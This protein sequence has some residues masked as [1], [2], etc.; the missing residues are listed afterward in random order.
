MSGAVALPGLAGDL[1]S[2]VHRLAPRTKV[3]GLTAVTLVAVSAGPSRWPV[4]VA[5]LIAL[6]GVAATA[7]VPVAVAARR[8]RVVLPL[9]VLAAGA[10]PLVRAGGARIELGPVVLWEEGLLALSAV[11]SKA[12]IGTLSAVL[13]GATTSFPQILRALQEL[14]VPRLFVVIAQTTHR[15]LPVVIGE[16]RR[17]HTALLARGWRPRN[18]LRAAPVGRVAGT[19]FL[20]AHARGERV[21]RAMLART[22]T[23]TLPAPPLVRMARRD[24]VFA[25]AVPGALLAIRALA[26]LS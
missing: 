25:I 5:C 2:P 14:R 3:L 15:Y 6:A 7:R 22:F 10:L 19:L 18:A 16:A 4:W 12:T 11:A 26:E 23:G 9:V 1:E 17:T 20:R 21:H 13:L 24:A 8:A